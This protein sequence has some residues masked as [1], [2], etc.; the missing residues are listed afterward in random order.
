M[1]RHYM[2]IAQVQ[3]INL[4]DFII[5]IIPWLMIAVVIFALLI[6][7]MKRLTKRQTEHMVSVREHNK[8]VEEQLAKIIE[9]LDRRG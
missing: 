7:H 1:E 2:E 8:R 3:T 6:P 5:P 9:L 4:A